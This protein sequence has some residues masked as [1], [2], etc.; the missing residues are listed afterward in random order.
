MSTLQAQGPFP[1][2]TER[3][4]MRAIQAQ[5][6]FPEVIPRPLMRMVQAQGAFPKVIE[7]A[8]MWGPAFWCRP[9]A[10]LHWHPR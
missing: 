7:W 6:A 1:E 8:M 2:V 4:L 3:S 10:G 5:G 9:L